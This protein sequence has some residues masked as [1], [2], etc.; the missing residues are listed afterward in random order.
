LRLRTGFSALENLSDGKDTSRAWKNIKEN[1]KTSAKKNLGLHE[2]E[3]HKP[4]FDGECLNFLDQRK[5]VK[6]QWV[7]E[8]SQSN[9][10]NLNTCNL[11]REASRH[12]RK[13]RRK[14]LK[15]RNLKLTV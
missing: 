12:F 13:K 8:P 2:F 4:R 11:R 10:D 15:L 14:K 6:M 3:Q 5:Q 9:V 7:Q 1:I